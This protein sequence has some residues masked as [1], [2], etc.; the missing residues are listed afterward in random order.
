MG[1]KDEEMKENIK[2]E[3]KVG[4]N[5]QAQ[6]LAQEDTKD[7]DMTLATAAGTTDSDLPT[8]LK[9]KVRTRHVFLLLLIA[10]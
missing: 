9:R 8:S 7:H 3:L 2:P 6:A 4:G 10:V 1:I 5:Q